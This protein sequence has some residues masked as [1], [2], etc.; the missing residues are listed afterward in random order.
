MAAAAPRSKEPGAGQHGGDI[1]EVDFRF[2]TA[3]WGYWAYV[4]SG[5]RQPSHRTSLRRT[6]AQARTIR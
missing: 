1:A 2:I 4:S 6:A 3:M 5:L